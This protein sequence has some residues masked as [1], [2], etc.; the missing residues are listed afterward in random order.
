[1]IEQSVLKATKRGF[2]ITEEMFVKAVGWPPEDDDLERCNCERTDAGH[3]HCGWN[4]EYQCPNFMSV[5]T[6]QVL[7]GV[8]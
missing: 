6:I 4:I 5:R 3:E 1:M 7:R 8:A 2:V